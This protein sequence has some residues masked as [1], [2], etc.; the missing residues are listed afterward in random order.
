MNNK[1]QAIVGVDDATTPNVP[2]DA[3]AI[4]TIRAI[5]SFFLLL[6]HSLKCFGGVFEMPITPFP[7]FFPP[8]SFLPPSLPPSPPYLHP[9]QRSFQHALPKFPPPSPP[10]SHNPSSSPPSRK[11]K[12]RPLHRR[13]PPGL[14]QF[15]PPSLPSQ[16]PP[17][18]GCQRI[19]HALHRE[20]LHGLSTGREGGREGGKEGRREGE[21]G[22]R[23]QG[24]RERAY[25]FFLLLFHVFTRTSFSPPFPTALRARC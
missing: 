3:L 20:H 22:R 21:Q 6:S 17:L 19:Q 5:L 18:C 24:A 16:S 7:P 1:R 23:G 10:S 4:A 9:C 2:S 14:P 15:L 25:N 8:P 11:R 13:N 12:E